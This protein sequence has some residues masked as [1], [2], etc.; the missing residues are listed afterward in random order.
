M[1][2]QL[3]NFWG[4]FFKKAA[5]KFRLATNVHAPAPLTGMVKKLP[6]A[7]P[8]ERTLN[9]KDIFSKARAD[10]MKTPSVTDYGKAK[11]QWQAKKP[12]SSTMTYGKGGQIDYTAPGKTVEQSKAIGQQKALEHSQRRLANAAK[13]GY[14]D[15]Q[16]VR[17]GKNT[18][19][20]RAP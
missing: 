11:A 9:Y 8:A 16:L 13:G 18:P 4:G 5:F 20:N 15:P 3:G 2:E 1:S 7:G 19:P 10:K 14:T 12:P 17:A 6:F